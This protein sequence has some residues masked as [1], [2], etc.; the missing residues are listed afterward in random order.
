MKNLLNWRK[1]SDVI[2]HGRLMQFTP[3]KDVYVYFRYDDDN[4]VL[5]AFNRGHEA[6]SIATDRFAERLEGLPRGT[7]VITGEAYDVSNT[8]ELAPRSVIILQLEQ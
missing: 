4:T 8:L 7:D 2:H 3:I 6:A 1:G 5:V